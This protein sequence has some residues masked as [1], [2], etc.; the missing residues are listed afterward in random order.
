[1]GPILWSGRPGP[2]E[3]GSPA[4]TRRGLALSCMCWYGWEV[5]PPLKELQEASSSLA[6]SLG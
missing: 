6:R 1:M 5:R 3:A 2:G 4:C